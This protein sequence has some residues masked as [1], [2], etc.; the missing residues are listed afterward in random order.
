[1]VISVFKC[2]LFSQYDPIETLQFIFGNEQKVIGESDLKTIYQTFIS[3]HETYK[4]SEI[5][6]F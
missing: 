2:L 5:I 1:M 3:I 6:L 4:Y